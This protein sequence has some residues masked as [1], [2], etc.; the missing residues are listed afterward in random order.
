MEKIYLEMIQNLLITGKLSLEEFYN[1][2]ETLFKAD[3]MVCFYEGEFSKNANVCFNNFIQFKA[4]FDTVEAKKVHL[5]DNIAK[6]QLPIAEVIKPE[7]IIPID[8]TSKTPVAIETPEKVVKAKASAK[9][10]NDVKAKK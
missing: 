5:L 2:I 10:K 8:V 9:A 1:Y 7:E 6:S 3:K 4:W